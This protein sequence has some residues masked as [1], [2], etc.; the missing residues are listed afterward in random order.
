MLTKKSVFTA[1][2]IL[3]AAQATSA[4]DNL[5]RTEKLLQKGR[6]YFYAAVEEE[7]KIDS[8]GVVFETLAEEFPR[9]VGRSLTYQGA[10][11]TL[12]G[13]HAFWAHTKYKK[14]KEGL[15]IMERG[16]ELAPND[17]EALFIYGTT[18]HYL[19]FFFNCQTEAKEN[20]EHIVELLPKEYGAYDAEILV[21]VLNFLLDYNQLDEDAYASLKL[22]KNRLQANAN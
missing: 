9:Y 10:L 13:K 20:F 6:A 17:I 21:N 5:F 3:L 12:E 7:D 14:V 19:P 4:Q 22:L 15:K 18:C 11:V 8:A 16:L 1:L 2:F